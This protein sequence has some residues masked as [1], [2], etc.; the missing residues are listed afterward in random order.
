MKIEFKHVNGIPLLKFTN[1]ENLTKYSLHIWRVST[2]YKND[3]IREHIS[4]W[5]DKK[6]YMF[7]ILTPGKYFAKVFQPDNSRFETDTIEITRDNLL[8][9]SNEETLVE[10]S[11][12]WEKYSSNKYA[13]NKLIEQMY[14]IG[15]ENIYKQISPFIKESTTISIFSSYKTSQL[16]DCIFSMSFFN[17]KFKFPKFF[18]ER[19]ANNGYSYSMSFRNYFDPVSYA[20]FEKDDLLIIIEES[21]SKEQSEIINK[22]IKKEAKVIYLSQVISR[23]YKKKYLIDPIINSPAKNIY[24]ELPTSRKIKNP[25]QSEKIAANTSISLVRKNAKHFVYPSA[26]NN[27]SDEYIQNVLHGWDL[28]RNLGFDSLK[29]YQSTYANVKMGHRIIPKNGINNIKNNGKVYFFG[30]SVIYGIGSD[31]ENTLPALFAKK[32]NLITKNL[33]NFS[34]NDFV[35]GT[36]LIKKMSFC[37]DDVII[38]GS[39]EILTEDEQFLF[40]NYI[41]MQAH[42]DH[43]RK[44]EKDVFLDM[45]HLNR[46]GYEIMAEVL[47][48]EAKF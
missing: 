7:K 48:S 15:Q 37:K 29:D 25:S 28:S 2:N 44:I 40:D 39:H 41:S 20:N 23:A 43:P 9:Y 13:V 45:T 14:I 35:R 22:A 34:M 38:F 31:D 47:I 21:K 42:F 16:S 27:M 12:E 11:S 10:I 17:G 1:E 19:A 8:L 4:G 32:T 36:N 6:T 33:A 26:L 30:N 3:R 46:Y 5:Q 24:I 18:G